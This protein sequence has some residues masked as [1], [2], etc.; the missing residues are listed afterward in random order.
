MKKRTASLLALMLAAVLGLCSCGQISDAASGIVSAAVSSA[1][2]EISSAISEGME[3]LSEGMNDFSEGMSE[4]KSGMSEAVSAI[5]SAKENVTDARISVS[6][7]LESLANDISNKI[8][9]G[10]SEAGDIISSLNDTSAVTDMPETVISSDDTT[11]VPETKH[12]TF[13]NKTRYDEHYK[14][15]GAEFGDITQ[16]EYLELANELINSDS[17]RV[18]HKRSKDNDYLFFDQDTEYFLVLSEEGFIRTFF[19]PTAGINY[20]N[21]Q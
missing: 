1:G 10:I 21:R 6:E 18:L 15:H 2:A 4:L 13:K 19:I 9:S 8:E 12:Y 14:K 3:D 7:S 5:D 17:D 20:Y 11:T 16:E